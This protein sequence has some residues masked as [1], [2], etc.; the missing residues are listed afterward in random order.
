[1]KEDFL[2][3]VWKYKVF[4]LKNL[5]TT[6]KETIE[7]VNAGFSNTNSGPDFLHAKLKIANQLWAGNVEIHLKTS[8]WYAHHHEKDANYD[9]VILHVVWEDDATVFMKNNKP[10]PTLLL[11]PLVARDLLEKYQ[12]LFS[13]ETRWIPCE[14][15]FSEVPSFVFNNWLERLYFERLE[16]KASLITDLLLQKKGDYEAVLFCLLA[17]NFGLNVNGN[18]FLAMAASFDFS[19]LRKE[20]FDVNTLAALLYG[21]AHLLPEEATEEYIQQLQKE[22]VYVQHK[23][24]L[25]PIAKNQFQFFRMRP[26]NFPTVR[27]AQLVALYHAHQNLFAV[28]MDTKNKNDFYKLFS[29]AVHSFWDTHYT[30]DKTAKKSSKKMTKSFVDLLLINTII[31][32]QFVYKKNR[33]AFIVAEFLP[34]IRQLKAEKNQ[35]VTKFSACGKNADNAF[36]TQALLELHTNYCSQKKCLDCAIGNHLLR[37][38][39]SSKEF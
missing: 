21:Q 1:M 9:A 2:H 8:D 3:Y 29:V 17:K 34:L 24:Q 15:Q 26:A 20:R 14:K 32:L 6:E 19:I 30:F 33:A 31:P 12:K 23:Y 38:D 5:Q 7:V 35:I 22:Y 28:L 16:H 37:K 18:A 4:S 36:Q 13:K 10:L 25:Q 39:E 11:K 27:M